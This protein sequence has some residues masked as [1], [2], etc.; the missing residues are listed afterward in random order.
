[1][2]A[3]V[4]TARKS[5]ADIISSGEAEGRSLSRSL[6][7]FTISGLDWF[8]VLIKTGAL[9]GAAMPARPGRSG[10]PPFPGFPSWGSCS[11][12]C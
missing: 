12:C 11:A 7:P 8:S 4:I 6:G 2:P 3:T 9:C 10:F 5:V 1:M